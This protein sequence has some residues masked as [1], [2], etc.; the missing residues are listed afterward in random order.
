MFLKIKN[1]F[2]F[3]ALVIISCVACASSKKNNESSTA[4]QTDSSSDSESSDT[5]QTDSFFDTEIADELTGN[6]RIPETNFV[7]ISDGSFIFGSPT[8][9]PCRAPLIEIETSVTLTHSFLIAEAEISQHEWQALDLPNPSK[10][11]GENKPVTFISFYEAAVWCNKLS[12]MEGYDTCYDFSN[13]TGH[14]GSGYPD[15]MEQSDELSSWNSNYNFNCPSD[16]HKFN[17]YYSCPGYRLPTTAE[18]EY[19]AKAGTTSHTYGGDVHYTALSYC[20]DE[21]ALNDIAWYCFN[22]GDTLHPVKQKL[23]NPWGLYDILGN[24][25][26]WTDF[27]SDGQSLDGTNQPSDVVLV[28]PQGP[29][30]GRRKDLRG[31]KFK[32]TG[33]YTSPSYQSG[34]YP[35]AK[36]YDSGFRP[37]RT[38]F[39]ETSTDSDSST[40]STTD[41]AD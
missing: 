22:S 39:E 25:Y 23:P 9:R 8:E 30:I 16:I 11:V 3:F 28:D 35:Y 31:G 24:V 5:T 12:K 21:P 14:A 17:N 38:L 27:W 15:G 10:N 37:V 13:C 32:L 33:C 29:T 20:E 4:N 36:R 2:V 34:D 6:E 7:H 18:W 26:E 1:S 19:A 40:D 41:S